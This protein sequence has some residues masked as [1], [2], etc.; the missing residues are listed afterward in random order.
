MTPLCFD[1]IQ[2]PHFIELSFSLF[3]K[4]RQKHQKNILQIELNEDSRCHM[5]QYWCGSKWHV[6]GIILLW[7]F[8]PSPELRWTEPLIKDSL[9]RE[10]SVPPNIPVWTECRL[11]T[12]A[13]I[14]S[15]TLQ[16]KLLPQLEAGV[17]GCNKKECK[18]RPVNNVY[19][20]RWNHI[21]NTN[22]QIHLTIILRSRM[23]L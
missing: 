17:M 4:K 21:N 22:I 6:I 3:P 1:C 10:W 12:Q 9:F 8:S 16:S 13:R 23:T 18:C 2:R 11:T 20:D 15:N 5:L 19:R 14:Q 7:C